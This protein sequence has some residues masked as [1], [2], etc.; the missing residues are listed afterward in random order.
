MQYSY[1]MINKILKLIFFDELYSKCAA[2]KASFV[3]NALNLHE[4]AKI[5]FWIV[6]FL[7]YL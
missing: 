7:C 5:R 1:Y 6:I 4:R 2:R 3:T